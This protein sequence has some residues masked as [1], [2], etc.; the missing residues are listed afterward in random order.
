MKFLSLFFIVFLVIFEESHSQNNSNIDPRII[1]GVEAPISATKFQVSI[2]LKQYDRVFGNGHICGGSLIGPNKVLT[3]A[4]CLYNSDRKRYRKA[5]EFTVVMGTQ[6]RYTRVNGTI[7]SDVSSITYMNSFSLDT[8]LDDV[9]LM[10]LKTGLPVNQT[11][12]TIEPIVLSNSSTTAGTTC[13]VSGWGKTSSGYL[14]SSLMMANVSIIQQSICKVSY[15]QGLT[16]GMLCAGSL[17][18]GTDSCQG[19]SGGPLVCDNE[20]VGIVSWGNGCA[21]PGFPGVYSNV[22]YYRNWIDSRN[23]SAT[24]GTKLGFVTLSL[25]LATG[26]L[27]N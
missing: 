7:V 8:M 16:G 3:A 11:H 18:G 25:T 6:N 9:G 21:Q 22:S 13:Q 23:A 5:K 27:L 26:F 15:G 19:D 10:F 4:H 12:L 2:R 20:L 24:F 14:S 17:L 1:N